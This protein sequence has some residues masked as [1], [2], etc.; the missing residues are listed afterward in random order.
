MTEL[1]PYLGPWLGAIPPFIYALVVHPISAIWVALLFL[2]IHQIEGHIVVP[3]V[4]GS[5]LRLNPLLVIFGLLAG[6]EIYGLPG[7]SSRCRC[8]PPRG[9]SGSS[10]PSGS[11]S[12]RGPS[13]P[14]GA[15]EVEPSSRRRTPVAAG[16]RRVTASQRRRDAARRAR[17]SSRRYGDHVALEPTDL[18]VAAGEALALVGPN[19]AGKSTLL[20]ML[21]GALEPSA[22]TVERAT[23]VRVGWV[24][25]RAGALRAAVGRARTSSCSRGWRAR[26][27]AG[28]ATAA[29]PVRAARRRRGQRR[30]LGRQ[31][32]AA[33]PRDRAARRPDVLLLDEPTAAL[34]PRQRRRLWEIARPSRE[35]GGAVVFAT[36]N[37]EELERCA[38]R[39][40]R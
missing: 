31:P 3:N 5:A 22:G 21:A 37:G 38:D 34:D 32:P 18:E 9:R 16:R 10:S 29:R 15:V 12:S 6:G 27:R 7:S 23:G 36:Q 26:R 1:I 8:S 17:A 24:P 14:A 20:A 2:V 35:G 28:D 4:M 33:Q 40:S 30:A 13:E 11:S 19:G 39:S 25:Q